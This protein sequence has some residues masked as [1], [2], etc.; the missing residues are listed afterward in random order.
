MRRTVGKVGGSL[1]DL[2]Y[3]RDRLRIWIAR[4]T[5]Q[6]LLVPG[7][8]AAADIVRH[9]DRVHGLGEEAAHWFALRALTVNAHFLS[10]L[11]GA[12]VVPSPGDDK[13]AVLDPHAFCLA[14]EGRPGSLPH[15]W[16]ATSDAI[17]ARVAEVVTADLVLLKS[18]DLPPGMSWGQAAAAGLVDETF[19]AVVR[20]AGLRIGWINLRAPHTPRR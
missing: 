3:L 2:P 10:R 8:G 19:D 15:A 17:A 5:G 9:L 11:V 4:C 13:V 20:R 1:Y 7:G 16:Q 14:D 12:P 18:A 6:V